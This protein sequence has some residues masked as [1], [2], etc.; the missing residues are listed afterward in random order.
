MGFTFLLPRHPLRC[1]AARC[2]IS[3]SRA[4]RKTPSSHWSSS[5]LVP[6]R[7]LS[8]PELPCLLVLRVQALAHGQEVHEYRKL[9]SFHTEPRLRRSQQ[10]LARGIHTKGGEIQSDV[11]ELIGILKAQLH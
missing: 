3:P 9:T 6:L 5:S 1:C 4:C 10:L 7:R 11:R 2:H 8:G